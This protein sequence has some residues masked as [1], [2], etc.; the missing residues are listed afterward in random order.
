MGE[1]KGQDARAAREKN[2]AKRREKEKEECFKYT[3]F[4][5]RSINIK[6]WNCMDRKQKVNKDP[7]N[8]E[9]LTIK[10]QTSKTRHG[11]SSIKQYKRQTLTPA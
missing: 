2:V 3:Y 7:I 10:T 9:H 8:N 1:S 4:F 11:H 6:E 5:L